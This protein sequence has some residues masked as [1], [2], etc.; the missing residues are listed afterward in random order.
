MDHNSYQKSCLIKNRTMS[1]ET[2]GWG[3]FIVIIVII[4]I[5]WVI[6]A[7]NRTQDTHIH[8]KPN[9]DVKTNTLKIRLSKYGVNYKV[10]EQIFLE[11]NVSKGTEST[12]VIHCNIPN[13]QSSG[14]KTCKLPLGTNIINTTV[15]VTNLL[16]QEDIV[17]VAHSESFTKCY[18]NCLDTGET[19]RD[20]GEECS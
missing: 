14:T 3:I 5:I 12:M 18:N 6:V 10:V 19:S 17:Q 7:I 8:V 11:D 16:D 2:N 20:C 4:I 9:F 13:N 1:N 15:R